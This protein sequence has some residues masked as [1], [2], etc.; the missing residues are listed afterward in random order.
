MET[1]EEKKLGV[2][3]VKTIGED[4]DVYGRKARGE[5]CRICSLHMMH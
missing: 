1:T 2:G 4:K 3:L 5:L